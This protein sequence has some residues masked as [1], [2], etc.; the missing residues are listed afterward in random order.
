Q[1]HRGNR[2]RGCGLRRKLLLPRDGGLR[3]ELQFLPRQRGESRL[4]LLADL[5]RPAVPDIALISGLCSWNVVLPLG[6]ESQIQRPGSV[7][8][9]EANRLRELLASVV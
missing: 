5:R 3:R 7:A 9:I 2:P 6:G 8:G 1:R 4:E